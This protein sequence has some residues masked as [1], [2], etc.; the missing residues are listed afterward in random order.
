VRV[1]DRDV[2]LANPDK[3]LWPEA[4]TTKRD[5]LEYAVAVAPVLLP[6]LADRALTL[7]RWPDGVGAAGF[8]EKHRPAG[9]PPWVRTAEMASER[10]GT[11]E[12]VVVDGVAALA[13]VANLAAIE[14]HVPLAT[15]SAPDTPTAMVFDLDPGAPATVVE[16][17]RVALLIEGMLGGL[18]L[19]C[20]PKTSGS[21]G[22]Q[23][24]VPLNDPAATFADTKRV[25]LA[26]AETLAGARPEL[27]VARQ[28][29][30][31]RRGRVLVDWSQNDPHKT[32]VAAY[33]PRART[34]PTVS[35]PVTWDEVRAGAVGGDPAA[36]AFE[37][38]AVLERVARDGDLFGAVLSRTQTLPR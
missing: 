29:R 34:R 20:F 19:V 16:C 23:V 32:T 14:L 2:D 22:L 4:G 12:Y 21:K 8:F 9:T 7:R 31:A 6:H 37:P 13:W 5:L 33:S 26:V 11:I 18:G 27:V 38:A 36:L 28:T 35:T 30:A 1:G 25:S 10:S 15:V 24:Y 3:V 17:C